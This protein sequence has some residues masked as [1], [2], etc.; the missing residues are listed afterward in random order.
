MSA[1]SPLSASPDVAGT[2][3][4]I[5]QNTSNLLY[6]VK[7]LVVVNIIGVLILVALFI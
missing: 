4:R 7:I 6:F 3:Q 1:L 5:E 2:L